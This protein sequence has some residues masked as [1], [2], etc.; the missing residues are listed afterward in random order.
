MIPIRI[1]GI[2]L[3]LLCTACGNQ[4]LLNDVDGNQYVV[5]QYGQQLWMTENL[6]VTHDRSGNPVSHYYPGGD[7]AQAEVYGLLYDF[8]AACEVCP[9]G[10][11]LPTNV[12]WEALFKLAIEND[13]KAFKDNQFWEGESNS[14]ETGFSIRPAGSGNNG[15]YPDYFREKTLFWSSTKEDTHFVWTYILERDMDTVRRASQHP[16]YAFSVR[17]IKD[18][19][20]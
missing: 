4:G 15:E 6:R 11:R 13:A 3:L 12:E 9:D 18:N 1:W 8:K 5:K 20:P 10:W 2:V 16:T 19:V 17:C 7:P 14:N